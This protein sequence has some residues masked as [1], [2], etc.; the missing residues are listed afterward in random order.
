[1]KILVFVAIVATAA[2][3]VVGLVYI[4]TT[5]DDET[6][7][8]RKPFADYP[9]LQEFVDALEIPISSQKSIAKTFG[10]DP[11]G[12][13]FQP[14]NQALRLK[15]SYADVRRYGAAELTLSRGVA[16]K[17]NALF[18]C[19]PSTLAIPD[20]IVGCPFETLEAGRWILGIGVT[21][22]RLPNSL[23]DTGCEVGT[24]WDADGNPDTNYSKRSELVR[25]RPSAVHDPFDATDQISGMILPAGGRWRLESLSFGGPEKGFTE[26]QPFHLGFIHKEVFGSLT[27]R[28][29]FGEDPLWRAFAFCT[30]PG[31]DVSAVYDTI[32]SIEKDPGGQLEVTTKVRF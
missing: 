22:Q 14:F 21:A 18:G 4:R 1:V 32:P 30:F 2:A 19:G 25:G 8:A 5:A 16:R 20:S 15:P 10:S 27:A 12:D 26:I 28:N 6:I 29:R 3:G 11:K 9:S 17:W 23:T 7:T 24:V 13:W 31:E